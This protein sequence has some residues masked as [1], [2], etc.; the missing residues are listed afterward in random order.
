M[1]LK[2]FS[3]IIK[4]SPTSNRRNPLQQMRSA[5]RC[6]M[7]FVRRHATS[8]LSQGPPRTAFFISL[9][10]IYEF[11]SQSTPVLVLRLNTYLHCPF[12]L[13]NIFW[14][15][16]GIHVTLKTMIMNL[17][18]SSNLHFS[19]CGLFSFCWFSRSWSPAHWFIACTSC[20]TPLILNLS[21]KVRGTALA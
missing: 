5:D 16:Y 8:P 17:L 18:G 6:L 3:F 1:K 21:P 12:F 14:N 7:P 15:F 2:M 10:G 20:H 9:T 13:L 19:Q 11:H 4:H